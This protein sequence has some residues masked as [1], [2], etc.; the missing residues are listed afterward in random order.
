MLV[1]EGGDNASDGLWILQ[2]HCVI[3]T[4]DDGD[5]G[6]RQHGGNPLGHLME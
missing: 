5:A 2:R 4:A 6:V 1:H 3:Y